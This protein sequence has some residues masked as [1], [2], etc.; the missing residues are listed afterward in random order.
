MYNSSGNLIC[1]SGTKN[2]KYRTFK[3]T[4]TGKE[5]EY[6]LSNNGNYISSIA[7]STQAKAA[8][9]AQSKALKFTVG[10][11]GESRF[12]ICVT[13]QSMQSLHC[14]AG[15]KVVGWDTKADASQWQLIAVDMNK[16]IADE[17]ALTDLY[18]K[19][20]AIYQT[21]VD[22]SVT[23]EDNIVFKDGV[24]VISATL[25]EDFKAMMVKAEEAQTLVYK[26]YYDKF[27]AYIDILTEMIAKVKAGYTLST[28]IYGIEAEIGDSV[29]Y[30][31]R[32]RK[33][34]SVTAPGVYIIN[35][36]KVHLGK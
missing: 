23:V 28:G 17:T 33:I 1:E 36:K 16:E 12:Y 30:D 14:D 2:P 35:G 4:S 25:M 34:K 24:N 20:F 11:A 32:G 15:K 21:I 13:G 26:K 18:Y 5:N 29:I 6:Y 8:T 3:F 19:A 10:D 31:I 9:S 7:T 22:D 27:P